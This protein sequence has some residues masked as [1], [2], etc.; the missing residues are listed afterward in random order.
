M[1]TLSPTK[2]RGLVADALRRWGA[3]ADVADT[4][5]EHL[6]DADLSGHPSHGTRQMIRY[7]ELI[8][9]REC[10]IGV[11]PVV[12]HSD[13][14]LL[15]IDGKSG[16]GHPAMALAVDHAATKAHDAGV[17]I[18]TVI[19]CGHTGRMGAWAERAAAQGMATL[20]ALAASDP[21]F[22][23]A[24]GPGARPALQTNP[25][26]IGMPTA[27]EP[28]VLDIATSVI[29]GGKVMVA[30]AAGTSLPEGAIVD[31]QGKPSVDPADFFSGG[32]LLPAAGH[33]GFGLGT[34]IEA[35]AVCLTGAD[36]V[37]LKPTSG[38]MII[39]V[40][41]DAFR[42]RAE[43]HESMDALRSR[44]RSS[45]VDSTVYLPGEPEADSRK[46][47][48]LEIDDDVLEVLREVQPIAYEPAVLA[49]AD[50][51]AGQFDD[52]DKRY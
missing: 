34:M 42:P 45:G 13:G 52:L 36:G 28:L 19:Q 3:S 41:A 11:E 9:R 50:P 1:P 30:H 8:A 16:L 15:V 35:L 39:C 37:G 6:V 23:L 17:A 2:A 51:Q 26:T 31:A 24:A 44:I 48:V 47:S 27:D 5:A 38:A 4:V 40:R 10:D 14:E 7:R 46:H 20:I 25:L 12:I 32:A 33:K 22:V 43:L 21:P 18:A 49:P 29:A